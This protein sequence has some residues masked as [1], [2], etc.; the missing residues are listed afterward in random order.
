MYLCIFGLFNLYSNKYATNSF[1]I[2]FLVETSSIEKS[3]VW[4][5]SMSMQIKK[6]CFRLFPL[7][8]EDSFLVY[9]QTPN[10]QLQDTR[11]GIVVRPALNTHPHQL[12]DTQPLQTGSLHTIIILIHV[13]VNIYYQ[14]CFLVTYSLILFVYIDY[15]I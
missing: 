1:L 5:I 8:M 7:W 3:N 4:I 15:N 6:N 9:K 12:S 10:S 11:E 13:F 14:H 2:L